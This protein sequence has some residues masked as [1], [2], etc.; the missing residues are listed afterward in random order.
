MTKHSNGV[1]E[2][3]E[4][5]DAKKLAK[6]NDLRRCVILFETD[7]GQFGYSSY[8]KTKALCTST[9]EIMDEI[10]DDLHHRIHWDSERLSGEI[11]GIPAPFRL[12]GDN[13]C[14]DTPAAD[15]SQIYDAY[16][17]HV[18]KQAAHRAIQRALRAVG[19]TELLEAVTEYANASRGAD[20]NYIPHPATWFN[21][22]R[23]DDDRTQWEQSADTSREM[24][25]K[26]GS[27]GGNW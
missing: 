21:Q 19:F 4:V 13:K 3:P 22:G 2:I 23:W 16:P 1:R 10:F 27:Y 26:E 15:V 18:G 12:V 6:Q 24:R 8:G 25:H 5:K 9:R 17:R 14:K 7:E 20:K 11:K